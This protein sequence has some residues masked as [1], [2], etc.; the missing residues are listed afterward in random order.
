MT[1]YAIGSLKMNREHYLSEIIEETHVTHCVMILDNGNY[2]QTSGNSIFERVVVLDPC[3]PFSTISP[4]K[5]AAPT[6]LS[7]VPEGMS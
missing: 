5:K 7:T 2:V 3:V 4:K 1:R 6:R